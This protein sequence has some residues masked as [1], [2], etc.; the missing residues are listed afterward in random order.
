MGNIFYFL[1]ILKYTIFIKIVDSFGLYKNHEFL[2]FIEFICEMITIDRN[3][4][5]YVSG[6][7]LFVKNGIGL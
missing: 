1:F 6:Y 7:K 5:S 2:L 3:F 4:L